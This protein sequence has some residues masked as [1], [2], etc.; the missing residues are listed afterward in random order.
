MAIVYAREASLSADEYIA[1]LSATT[2]RAKRPLANRER[3]AAML[4]GAN[5]IVT[6][7]ENGV[8]VG[9]ARCL[10]DGAWVCYCAELAVRE[11][12]QGKGVGRGILEHC[13]ELLGPGMGLI[14]AAEPEAVAFYERIGMDRVQHAFFH[15]RTDR[16]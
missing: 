13:Y 14:L 15:P 6:A 10:S 4:A 9:L 3:I 2:M 1:V 8:L 12:Q 16:S 5:I 7:R 11:D